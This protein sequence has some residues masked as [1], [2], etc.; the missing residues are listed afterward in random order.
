[1]VEFS[2]VRIQE[3]F[4]LYRSYLWMPGLFAALPVVFGWLAPKKTYLALGL[5]CVLLVPLTLNR[6]D[7]FSSALKLWDDVVKLIR[8]IPDFTATDRIYYN[9]GSVLGK[10][11]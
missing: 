5:V 2:T 10:L 9:R 7:T 3:P 8:D 4:V 1:V 11:G 6:I